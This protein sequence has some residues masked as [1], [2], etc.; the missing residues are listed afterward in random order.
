M[1]T[2]D[3]ELTNYGNLMLDENVDCE[4]CGRSM[5]SRFG[6]L[7]GTHECDSCRDEFKLLLRADKLRFE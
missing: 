6:G 3:A 4:F 2:T 7:I 1:I 5:I